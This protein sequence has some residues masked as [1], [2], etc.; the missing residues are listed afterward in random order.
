MNCPENC[1]KLHVACGQLVMRPGDIRHQMEQVELL[2]KQAADAG[3][4]LILFAEG[5]LHGYCLT[6]EVVSSA[7]TTADPPVTELKKI[8]RRNRIVI[9]VGAFE[10][11]GRKRY[12]SQFVVW[13]DGGILVQR[14]NR[15]T[16]DEKNAGFSVGPERRTIFE[17]DG[18][19]CA[20]A[21]CADA[22]IENLWEQLRKGQCQISLHPCAGG[23]SREE[24]RNPEDLSVPELRSR[25]LKAMEKVCFLGDSLL[26]TRDMGIAMVATNLAGDDGVA[27]YHPGHSSIVDSRG[28]L[29]ALHPGEYVAAFLRPV[30]IHGEV[31]V[32]ER[33]AGCCAA[34]A[35]RATCQCCS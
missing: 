16:P 25:Y 7:I 18:V 6:P 30:M 4:R 24:M 15:I 33:P 19:R 22:G 2:S 17:V 32:Q 14:K 28:S 35:R 20:I 13:P 8:S 9:A 23:G 31:A 5:A 26:R 11:S 3:A 27:K 1:R 34:P 10:R 21:I 29:V 12:V